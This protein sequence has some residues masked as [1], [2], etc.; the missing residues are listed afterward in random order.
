MFWNQFARLIFTGAAAAAAGCSEPQAAIG[1][2]VVDI[3]TTK[4]TAGTFGCTVVLYGVGGPG[5][6]QFAVL[7]NRVYPDGNP[8]LPTLLPDFDQVARAVGMAELWA[9]NLAIINRGRPGTWAPGVTAAI[10]PDANGSASAQN[11]GALAFFDPEKPIWFD[12]KTFATKDTA[13]KIEFLSNDNPPAADARWTL[14]TVESWPVWYAGLNSKFHLT[15]TFDTAS[16]T[17]ARSAMTRP[18]TEPAR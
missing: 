11:D 7:V 6:N 15:A 2:A 10:D 16:S 13:G 3:L 9:T 14:L 1:P 12:P 5:R 18:S 8:I 4:I 17:F